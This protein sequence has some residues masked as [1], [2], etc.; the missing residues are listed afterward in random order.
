MYGT[1][2]YVRSILLTLR[3]STFCAKAQTEIYQ[4]QLDSLKLDIS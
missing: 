1:R 2:I 3:Y 4:H